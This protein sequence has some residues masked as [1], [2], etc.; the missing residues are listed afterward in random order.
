MKSKRPVISLSIVFIIGLAIRGVCTD[1]PKT[2]RSEEASGWFL[3]SIGSGI[4]DWSVSVGAFAGES[5]LHLRNLQVQGDVDVAPGLRAH[6]VVRSNRRINGLGGFRPHLDESYLEGYS[7][8]RSSSGVLSSSVKVG[9]AR[10]L[11][12]PYPDAISLFDQA[13]ALSDL[14]GA[15]FVRTDVDRETGYNGALVT[16]DYA[17]TSGF[18]AHYTGIKWGF[19]RHGNGNTIE[20][21]GFFRK[22][23]GSIHFEARGGRLQV[24]PE[25]LGRSETGYNTFLGVNKG[26]YAVGLLYERLRSQP[27]YTGIMVRFTPSRITRAFGKVAFDYDRNPQGIAVQLPLL[28]GSIGG[29][30]RTAPEDAELVGEIS[31]ERFRTFWQNGQVRNHYEHRVSSW[32]ETNEPGLKVVVDEVPWTLE[33]EAIYSPHVLLKDSLSD[34]ERE[35]QGPAHV[36]QKV[37][38]RFYR[39]SSSDGDVPCFSK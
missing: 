35:R 37:T 23:I 34:F 36:T 17:H 39:T 13:P 15:G 16:L 21:Y 32:G 7:F 14:D 18:G 10:Y 30:S 25:P 38:Y 29:L 11:R 5:E 20:G 3:P 9:A 22:D 27:Q 1:A 6:A 4:G 33:Y 26:Q 19:G 12:F 31:A 24:R 8:Y 2:G 28:M